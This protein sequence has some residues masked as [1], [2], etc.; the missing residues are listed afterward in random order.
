[1]Y[2]T[3]FL[4]YPLLDELIVWEKW[5]Q[6]MTC[7]H[8]WILW[9]WC[10]HLLSIGHRVRCTLFALSLMFEFCAKRNSSH[11]MPHSN[12]KASQFSAIIT[13]VER[14]CCAE[15]FQ[16]F[17][18][19]NCNWNDIYYYVYVCCCYCCAWCFVEVIDEERERNE[20]DRKRERKREGKSER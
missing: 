5:W 10:R 1:M 7:I 6:R 3:T 12:S 2:A 4:R 17:T 14:K 15:L 13:Y 16:N 19:L 9:Q 20:G 11:T 18:K 8:V